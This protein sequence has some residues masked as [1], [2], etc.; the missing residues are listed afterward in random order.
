[1]IRVRRGFDLLE[2]SCLPVYFSKKKMPRLFSLGAN[3]RR[4]E[5]LESRTPPETRVGGFN[6]D[7]PGKPGRPRAG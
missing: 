5:T 4:G 7:V 6:R 1:M 3:S 2:N